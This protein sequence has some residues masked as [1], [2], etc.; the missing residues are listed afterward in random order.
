MPEKQPEPI[1]TD[2]FRF[3][4]VRTPQLIQ[5]EKKKIVFIYHP[6]PEKSAF[7]KDIQ[8]AN[9]SAAREHVQSVAETFK[10][11]SGPAVVKGISPS[12]YSFSSWLFRNRNMLTKA[13]A[14]TESAQVTLL[15]DDQLI[16]VWDYLFDQAVSRDNP[17]VRQACLQLI[18]AQHFITILRD[19]NSARHVQRFSRSARNG[20]VPARQADLFLRRLA[21]SKVVMPKAFSVERETTGAPQD[22]T[23][24]GGV[25]PLDDDLL[26]RHQASRSAL[27]IQRYSAMKKE[28]RNGMTA[29]GAKGKD[30]A[31]LASVP[32][33][34]TRTFSADTARLIRSSGAK[35]LHL[36]RAE[37][38]LST[39]ITS[40][41]RKMN[42]LRKRTKKGGPNK[43][44][45][46]ST[47]ISFVI[48]TD[49]DHGHVDFLMSLKT[50]YSAAF[51]TRAQYEVR[52]GDHP[53]VSSARVQEVNDDDK[54]LLTLRLF[55][56]QE[57]PDYDE[58][59]YQIKGS[60]TLDN[61]QVVTWDAKGS[62]Q[63]G[64]TTGRAAATP[65]DIAD[66]N[67]GHN[68]LVPGP[69][70]AAADVKLYGVNR[71]GIGVFRKVEQEVCC[72]V[73]GEVS[74]IEN[75]LAGEYK[76][77]STR[78]LTTTE[79][80]EEETTEME[81]EQQTDTAT[82]TRNELQSEIANELNRETSIDTGASLGVEGKF[83]GG[84]I[85]AEG[86]FNY[87]S[88][89]SASTSD[90]QALT[91]AQ[92][93][94]ANAL[95]RVL[96]KTTSKRT[97]RILQEYE[98]N[99]RHGFDNRTGTQHVTG[100]YRWVDIIYTN[101]LI[102][103]GK[104][105]MVEFLIPEP[106]RFYK[107][108]LN[109]AANEEAGNTDTAP[110]A[111]AP[112]SPANSE[113]QI[114]SY[115]DINEGNYLDLGRM[116][117]V[118]VPE[119]VT[120]DVDILT[121]SFGP[122]DDPDGDPD[123]N[124]KEREYQYTMNFMEFGDFS[125]YSG[126]QLVINLNFD[127]HLKGTETGTYFILKIANE[128]FRYDKDGTQDPDMPGHDFSLVESA[129]TN[130]QKSANRKDELTISLPGIKNSLSLTVSIKNVYNFS[131]NLGVTME[132]DAE[133]TTNWQKEVY[134]DIM[135]GYDAQVEAY[136]AELA[137]AEA[138]AENTQEEEMAA[139]L[140]DANRSIEQRELQRVAIEMLTKPFGIHQGENFYDSGPC[141]VPMVK[142]TEIW[143]IYSSHVKFFEQAFDWKL[144]AYIF[145]PYYWAD[146]CHWKDLLLLENDDPI[147]KAFL[148]SGMA[149]MVVPVRVGFEEAVDY[150]MD[151][152]DVWNGGGLVMDTDD[153]LY[154]SIDE[155]LQDIEGA[156]EE[157]WQTRVPTTL[158]IVQGKSVYL[159]DEGLPCCED[160]D[161]DT[162][163]LLK[164]S[165]AI[166]GGK[167]S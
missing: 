37:E 70:P 131:V 145:Y 19:P 116:Y 153:D 50:G 166:L 27:N 5:D 161:S 12:L 124:A 157:E 15:T 79:I 9:I 130:K 69:A 96:Q 68:T 148:Q 139:T 14:E 134:D 101:R 45:G 132:L 143:E 106:A 42:A 1:R 126:K 147:F 71:L 32:E 83:P 55:P 129:G 49:R 87:A 120:P 53:P 44:S 3:V 62:L 141:K 158:T 108:A 149:R 63:R 86:T 81:V 43:G 138:E 20:A 61:G 21:K 99:N 30:I 135:K 65:A 80:T 66:A 105:L 104:R 13:E 100:V 127:Y 82:A 88:S 41:S 24:N 160:V 48:S 122:S 40:E 144:M 18:V 38:M 119:P 167:S 140:A 118:T 90:T 128:T 8:G 94:T 23:D 146:K 111:E 7:L 47:G 77:R 89:T 112:V 17:V 102:N 150:Y 78:S 159:E 76:E 11:A 75:V 46:A 156:V 51:I 74:R 92:E 10:G 110:A 2:L 155:E 34:T 107:I 93:V 52:F 125:S 137:E 97:S 123:P 133:V 72:Y 58:N 33:N 26:R 16:T 35:G 6:A 91:Y 36:K 121:D 67:D 25:Q 165:A 151:T 162:T 114:D 109:A 56:G 152:G 85:S 59:A 28:L 84:S 57:V 31:S 136:E 22:S 117:D 113:Y 60:F 73:P 154:L 164:G 115:A 142:Q 98:E 163:T 54:D 4:T 39:K 29:A 103:Y 64:T 95:E